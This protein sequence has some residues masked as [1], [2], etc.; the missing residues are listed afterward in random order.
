MQVGVDLP[1]WAE[2]LFKPSRYKILYGGRGG[3]KSHSIAKA[4]LL[5]GTQEPLR[6]LCLREFQIS[7]RDSVHKLLCDQIEMLGLQGFYEVQQ[8]IIL[9]K[10]GTEITFDGLRHNSNKIRSQ[11]GI[12]I[13]WCEEAH[14]IS[15]AS[16]SVLIPTIRKPSS[17]IWISFNPELNTDETYQRFVLRNPKDSL[18]LKVDWRDN[19]WF[20]DVLRQ[21]ME[22]LKERDYDA[23]LNVWEG[24][25]KQAIEGAVYANEL[26]KAVEA[27]RIGKVPLAP[28]KPV[29]TFWDLGKRDHTSIWFVQLLQ[30]EYR[31]VDF[32]QN[33]GEDLQHYLLEL[34]K[35][36]Y[37]YGMHFLPHD[38]KQD[39]LGAVTIEKQIKAVYPDRVKVIDRVKAIAHGIEAVR[40]IFPLCYFDEEKCADGLNALRHYK[41]KV[42]PITGSFSKEPDHDE[43]SDAA[44][45]F[46]QI[47]QAMAS[48]QP[49]KIMKT[50]EVSRFRTANAGWMN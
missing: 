49:K 44:D 46:R 27:G 17:E 3:G 12:D 13:A 2:E 50:V 7:M 25:C 21:E 8:T 37:L 26:R 31:I 43:N 16:W 39:R 4:L 36:G 48:N 18:L 11:E 20:P 1:A 5:K 9:G 34:Q 14:S 45:A 42:D 33:R 29:D 23:Y 30:G 32:Y 40:A 22:D 38:S 6:I 24:A 10:N 19:P 41:Y 47:A 15:K 28:G 35:R